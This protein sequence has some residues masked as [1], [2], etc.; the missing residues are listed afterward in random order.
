MRVALSDKARKDL[1]EIYRYIS[2]RSPQAAENLVEA[3]NDRLNGLAHFPFIGR[4][5]S[6]LA[7]GLR[8][9]IVAPLCDLLHG[10]PR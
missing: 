5:R 2:E 8:S 3:V 10:R 7:L 6:T 9:V 1:L 4:E